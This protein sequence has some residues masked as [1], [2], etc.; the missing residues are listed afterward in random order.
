MEE[1]Y[2]TFTKG[3][4]LLMNRSMQKIV[5]NYEK[6]LNLKSQM[7]GSYDTI[8]PMNNFENNND[9]SKGNLYENFMENIFT[10]ENKKLRIQQ[11]SK[12]IIEKILE[13]LTD[14]NKDL[15]KEIVSL[16]SGCAEAGQVGEVWEAGEAGMEKQRKMSNPGNLGNIQIIENDFNGEQ[17]YVNNNS[18]FSLDKLTEK[19]KENLFN[20]N[21]NNSNSN[22]NNSFNEK[23]SEKGFANFLILGNIEIENLNIFNSDHNHNHNFNSPPKDD[24]NILTSSTKKFQISFRL[25]DHEEERGLYLEMMFNDVSKVTQLERE[26]TVDDCRSLYLSKVA[27]ELKN[28]LSSLVELQEDIKDT[29][30]NERKNKLKHFVRSNSNILTQVDSLADHSKLIC[31]IMEMF[32]KDFSVFANLKESCLM[33]CDPGVKCIQC[34]YPKVCRK[35]S[36]CNNCEENKFTFFNYNELVSSCLDSFKQLSVFENKKIKIEHFHAENKNYNNN[37]NNNFNYNCD[38]NNQLE[39]NNNVNNLNEKTLSCNVNKNYLNNNYAF[40]QNQNIKSTEITNSASNNKYNYSLTV[41][42]VPN[43]CRNNDHH[44]KGS[45]YNENFNLNVKD[46]EK[47]KDNV[48]I[49]QNNNNNLNIFN[50][51]V[52][53]V[54]PFGVRKD[55]KLTKFTH[56]TNINNLNIKKNFIK[57]S[58]SHLDISHH[59]NNNGNMQNNYTNE[60]LLIKTDQEILRS[61]IFNIIFHSYK[62]TFTG[63]IKITSEFLSKNSLLLCFYDTG[64]EVDPHFIK[65]LS[66]NNQKLVFENNTV[67]N[68]MNLNRKSSAYFN[69]NNNNNYMNF[70]MSENNSAFPL[71]MTHISHAPLNKLSHKELSH[72]TGDN[73]NK[74]FGL[75]IAHN[76]VN[77]MG[78][79]LKIE[80]NHIGNKYSFILNVKTQSMVSYIDMQRQSTTVNTFSNTVVKPKTNNE[81][82]LHLDSFFSKQTVINDSPFDLKQI[83]LEVLDKYHLGYSI[84]SSTSSIGEDFESKFESKFELKKND[85]EYNNVNIPIPSN[86]RSKILTHMMNTPTES[87][88]DP[89]MQ[90]IL[91]VDDEKLVRDTIKRYFKRISQQFDYHF[92]VVEAEN[93]LTALNLIHESFLSKNLFDVIIS[94]EYM[95]FMKG[96][97]FIKIVRHIYNDCSFLSRGINIISHTAFDTPEVKASLRENGA[98]LIWNKPIGYEEFKNYFVK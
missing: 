70:N 32:L 29:T 52:G 30:A 62:N 48:N 15:P 14:L 20:F 75:F 12:F 1:G 47:E 79:N 24:K 41:N 9:M 59:S 85:S 46:K 54:I 67:N 43:S 42:N 80:S 26:R 45:D 58:N 8:Y 22:L 63:E 94:D 82:I 11:D 17:F 57:M 95:P 18:N 89:I 98:D 72:L 78:S 34:K 35:C 90:K 31:K 51:K 64:L 16:F 92:E 10:T 38:Y 88:D 73:F 39:T 49:T 7:N 66:S 77:K 68:N 55:N 87:D 53:G 56:V 25:I 81:Q 3:K 4:I 93:A 83:N 19:I 74:Y 13:N 65:S 37:N 50:P 27:H 84:D 5:N 2:F 86:S 71:P 40:N 76:L 21:S 69:N 91:L 33:D 23:I 44:R 61:I 28:P 36:V 96:S 97:F 60:N 6:I